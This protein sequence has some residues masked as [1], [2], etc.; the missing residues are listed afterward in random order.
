MFKTPSTAAGNPPAQTPPLRRLLYLPMEISSRELD[1]R[2]LLA[3]LALNRGFEVVLGQKWLIERNVEAMPPGIYLSKSLTQRDARTIMRVQELGYSV[4]A[5]EEEV[6]GLVTK[7]DEL[8]WIADDAVRHT[9][10]IF[11][12]GEVNTSSMKLRFPFAAERIHMTIN[13]RWDLL[14]PNMRSIHQ[15]EVD[16]IRKRFGRFLLV[17]TNLGWTNSEKGPVDFMVQD[18]AR[19]GK[20]D[21]SDPAARSFI[22]NYLIMEGDNHR[23]VVGIIQQLLERLP[24]MSIVLRPHPSE[25]IDTWLNHFKG[26]P[27]LSVVRE[28]ASIPWILASEALIQTNCTTGVEAIALDHPALCVMATESPVVSRY[29][30]NRV[31]PVAH[32]VDQAVAMLLDHVAGKPALAYTDEMRAAFVASMSFDPDRMGAQTIMDALDNLLAAHAAPPTTAND[33]VSDWRPTWNYQWSLKDKNV[34]GTLFPDFDHEMIMERLRRI[35]G[36]LGINV[37]PSI[38]SCGSKV[39]LLTQKNVSM[40][41]RLQQFV[42]SKFA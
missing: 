37:N 11:I 27:R 30:A 31:N 42:R 36:A 32:S 23:A 13:P 7:P 26:A 25:R 9:D 14:R 41:T 2:L 12:G 21:L 5:I 10:A 4:A 8:R 33:S 6:P 3:A 40:P 19:Q 15:A 18:Q 1:S 17:N 22:E 28:G 34:R 35:A 39:A 16:A 20:L 24:D 29:V 38:Y